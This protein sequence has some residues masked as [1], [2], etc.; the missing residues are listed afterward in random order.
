MRILVRVKVEAKTKVK[1]EAKLIPEVIL[2]LLIQTKMI[3]K[4]KIVMVKMKIMP[5]A[6][7]EAHLSGRRL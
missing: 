7:A 3:A 6:P 2:I 4:K 1:L 5:V